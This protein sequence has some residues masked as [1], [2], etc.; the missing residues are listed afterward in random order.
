MRKELSRALAEPSAAASR[1]RENRARALAAETRQLRKALERA[2]NH[3]ATIR[4]LN[5][6]IVRLNGEQ[7]RLDREKKTLGL[8]SGTCE[9]AVRP[10][11]R[12]VAVKGD[13]QQARMLASTGAATHGHDDVGERPGEARSLV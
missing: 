11:M 1:A 4:T 13:A 9:A 5:A 7:R 6:E 3:K 12:F 2:E 8:V 10:S